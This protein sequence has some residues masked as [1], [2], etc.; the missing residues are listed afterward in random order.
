MGSEPNKTFDH[1]AHET[2]SGSYADSPGKGDQYS[3]QAESYTAKFDSYHNEIPEG[4]SGPKYD[5]D[6][7]GANVDKTHSDC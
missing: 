5:G 1:P 7:Y 3:P 4:T 2:G 6:H